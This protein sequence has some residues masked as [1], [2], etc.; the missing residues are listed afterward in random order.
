MG[1]HKLLHTASMLKR[2]IILEDSSAV[3]LKT[4][5]DPIIQVN[6]YILWLYP[7]E[8]DAYIHIR[9]CI[10]MCIAILFIIVK[11]HKKPRCPSGGDS[12]R[13]GGIVRQKDIIQLF[14]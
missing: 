10:L 13:N 5:D 14:F 12:E 2:T 3:P 1:Q 8:I 11:S 4:K 7:K 9:T 6:N